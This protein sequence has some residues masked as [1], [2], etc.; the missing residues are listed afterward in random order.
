MRRSDALQGLRM[1]RFQSVLGRYDA[2]EAIQVEAAEMLGMSER[3]FRRWCN[4]PA[5]EG[6][7]GLLDR[8]VGRRSSEVD[9]IHWTGIG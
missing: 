4:R 1:I 5:E 7:V 2:G 8:R 6:E 3:N 9:P